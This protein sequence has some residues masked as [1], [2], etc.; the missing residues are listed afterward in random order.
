MYSFGGFLLQIHPDGVAGTEQNE[1][2]SWTWIEVD[3]ITK[4]KERKKGER[5]C[6]CISEC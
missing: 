6:I 1:K 2:K 3:I 5:N 4:E